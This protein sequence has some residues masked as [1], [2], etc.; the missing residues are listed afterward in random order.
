MIQS[1]RQ[2]RRIV[3]SFQDRARSQAGPVWSM[4]RMSGSPRVFLY[5]S[6]Q[7]FFACFRTDV[8]Y[9]QHS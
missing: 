8:W 9:S 4:T 3:R 5:S 6:R 1:T 2:M 7:G